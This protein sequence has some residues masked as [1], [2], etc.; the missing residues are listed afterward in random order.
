MG[1][2][3]I[4]RYLL[5]FEAHGSDCISKSEVTYR[6]SQAPDPALGGLGDGAALQEYMLISMQIF[7]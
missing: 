2:S 7:Q 6:D 5:V 4:R 1:E 3:Y